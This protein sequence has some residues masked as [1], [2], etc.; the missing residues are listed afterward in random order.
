MRT[1]GL[2]WEYVTD[3]FFVASWNKEN[4][5]FFFC[6]VRHHRLCS[7]DDYCFSSDTRGR[8]RERDSQEKDKIG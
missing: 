3:F 4:I 1:V 5:N 6:F 8:E 7:N 2:D